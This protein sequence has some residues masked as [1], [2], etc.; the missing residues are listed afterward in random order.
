[1]YFDKQ[2]FHRLVLIYFRYMVS[3]E[4][5]IWKDLQ[6]TVSMT[7]LLKCESRSKQDAT[8]PFYIQVNMFFVYNFHDKICILVT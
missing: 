8:E 7:K 1:M 2:T 4:P 6:K 5:F 3:I